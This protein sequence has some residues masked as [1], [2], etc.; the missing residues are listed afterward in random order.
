MRDLQC[1]DTR[2]LSLLAAVVASAASP[3][4]VT[5]VSVAVVVGIFVVG[6]MMVR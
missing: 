6:A 2:A 5:V 4:L 3:A 1:T